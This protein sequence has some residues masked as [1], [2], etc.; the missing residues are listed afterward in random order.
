[1]GSIPILYLLRVFLKYYHYFIYNFTATQSP[2]I[3]LTY[4]NYSIIDAKYPDNSTL[5]SQWYNIHYLN[6]SVVPYISN[7]SAIISLNDVIIVSLSLDYYY[8][9]GD[10]MVKFFKQFVILDLNFEVIF[11]ILPYILTAP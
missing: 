4:N 5:W 8:Y 6:F 11:I 10:G 1:L 3:Y 2:L 9:D 7:D